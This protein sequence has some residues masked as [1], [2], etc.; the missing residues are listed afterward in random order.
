MLE[1]IDLCYRF[2]R[3]SY[4]DDVFIKSYENFNE[5][6]SFNLLNHISFSVPLGAMLHI[7]GENGA[8]KTTLLKIIAGLLTPQVGTVQFNGLSIDNNQWDYQKQICYVGHKLGVNTNLTPKEHYLFDLNLDNTIES[9]SRTAKQLSLQHVEN[10]PS[11][12]LS[13][14]Q[15]RRVSLLRILSSKAKLWILDEPFV[16]LDEEGVTLVQQCIHHH[17]QFGG[18]VLLSS[19]QSLPFKKDSYLE[20]WL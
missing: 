19:H 1:I 10:I 8:G 20:Y 6:I 18:V 12:F 9:W 2:E 15:L 7:R 5:K 14:G 13:A 4:L 17:L 11:G 3:N 16:A